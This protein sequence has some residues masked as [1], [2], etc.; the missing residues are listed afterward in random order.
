[1]T[2]APPY[3]V[4]VPHQVEKTLR[5]LRASTPRIYERVTAILQDLATDP[6]SGK[7]LKGAFIQYRSYRVGDYRILYRIETKAK[8]IYIVDIGHRREI[9]R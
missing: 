3:R 8:V 6:F 9:Y 5:R 4:E 7:G 2:G 1:M